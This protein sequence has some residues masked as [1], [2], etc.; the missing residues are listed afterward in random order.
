MEQLKSKK[1]IMI[2]IL[3]ILFILF[4]VLPMVVT[5]IAY[6]MN[7]GMRVEKEINPTSLVYE[8]FPD[9]VRKEISFPS[10]KGQ[11]LRGYVYSSNHVQ[12][13]KAIIVLSHGYLGVHENYLSQINYFTQNGFLVLGYD[14]TGCGNSD[15]NNMIG[16][17][18]SPIDL[19]SALTYVEK[20]ETLNNYPILLYGHSWGGYAVSAVLN[21]PHNVTAVVSRSGFNNSRDMLVEYGSRL[22]GDFISLLSPYAYIYEKVKFGNN[23]DKNGIKGID[24][25]NADVLLLHSKDDEVISLENSL[26]I[27]KDTFKSKDH[28]QTILY[29]A[30]T[31]DVV[32]SDANLKYHKQLDNELQNFKETYGCLENIPKD[33]LDNYYMQIDKE[34]YNEL[35]E[36]VMKQILDFLSSSIEGKI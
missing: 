36:T 33:I 28:V 6:E 14:N 7:F 31:H 27:H 30:K 18:Q 35:D 21:Y 12:N 1:K 9:L 23:V 19:D 8:D 13:P 22:Y 3:C 11:I 10:N 17:A 16:L 5:I 32:K 26:L 25:T 4:L 34:T 2:S 20:D 15:G 29:D 24:G